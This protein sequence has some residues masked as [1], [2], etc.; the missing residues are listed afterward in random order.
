MIRLYY[1]V[2]DSFKAPLPKSFQFNPFIHKTYALHP[3][4]Q[5]AYL[6]FIHG[7][8]V[9]KTDY[10]MPFVQAHMHH[11]ICFTTELLINLKRKAKNLALKVY[12]ETITLSLRESSNSDS[13]K[14]A[15]I[16][17]SMLNF[18]LIASILPIRS[19]IL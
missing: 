17:K 2:S 4:L 10:I 8:S 15:L 18:S 3:S 1:S 7:H 5:A 19:V 13:S 12:K 9:H 16:T 6:Y 11:I 14:D